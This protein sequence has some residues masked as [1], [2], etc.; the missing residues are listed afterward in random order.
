M[1]DVVQKTSL[2]MQIPK[3]DLKPG[4]AVAWNMVNTNNATKEVK[5]GITIV[6]VG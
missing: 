4:E 1:N 6:V 3:M 2:Q 5:G